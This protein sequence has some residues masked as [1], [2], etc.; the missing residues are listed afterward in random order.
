[1]SNFIGISI[2]PLNV[3][4]KKY[5]IDLDDISVVNTEKRYILLRGDTKNK[6]MII[7]REDLDAILD[8]V[9]SHM[10]KKTIDCVY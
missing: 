6:I 2:L 4:D 7:H 3:N 8:Y 1:M 9:N 5:F 10:Y